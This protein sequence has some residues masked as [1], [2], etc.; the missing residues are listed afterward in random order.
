[1]NEWV[2]SAE[3]KRFTEIVTVSSIETG[4]VEKIDTTTNE[5]IGGEG[6]SVENTGAG[7][8]ERMAIV[9][10]IAIGAFVPSWQTIEIYFTGRQANA[11]VSKCDR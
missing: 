8:A 3:T 10:V 1:M 5:I 6:G 4:V 9:S 2:H 7:R 11:H